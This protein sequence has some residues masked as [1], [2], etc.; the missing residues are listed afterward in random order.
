M[1]TEAVVWIVGS[2]ADIVA[3]NKNPSWLTLSQVSG[4]K[5]ALSCHTYHAARLAPYHLVTRLLEKAISLGVNLQVFTP[6]TQVRQAADQ[7]FRWEVDTPRGTVKT[8]TVI[9]ATNAYT[10]ALVPEMKGKIVPVRGMVARL[11]SPTAPR[12]T[13]SYMMRFSEFE[14]DYMIPRPDG[15]IIVGGGRRDYYKDLNEWFDVADDSRL[16]KGG[17]DYFDGYM[18]RHFYGWEDSGM[19]TEEVWSGSKSSVLTAIL[20]G[21]G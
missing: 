21:S 10:S 20:E 15:S 4:I 12:L 8:N 16:M 5:G 14:Y 1:A 17:P 19:R 2:I 7:G 13:D 6:V 11:A 9:Y 3:S 18:Q